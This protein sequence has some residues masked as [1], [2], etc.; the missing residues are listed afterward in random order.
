MVLILDSYGEKGA[1]LK[2][3]LCYLICLRR[4]IRSRAVTNR[5]Y[6]LRKE[7]YPLYVQNVLI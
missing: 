6:F 2:I 5:T 4:L 1:D 7:F 3:N